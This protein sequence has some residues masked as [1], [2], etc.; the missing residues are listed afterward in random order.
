M[1]SGGSK[2]EG[3]P[4]V[5]EKVKADDITKRTTEPKPPSNVNDAIDDL[6]PED[7]ELKSQPTAKPKAK[8]HQ[9]SPAKVGY[10]QDPENSKGP[11][12][13]YSLP[14]FDLN[15]QPKTSPS[16]SPAPVVEPPVKPGS[17]AQAHTSSPYDTYAGDTAPKRPEQ[18]NGGS[19]GI[20]VSK[21]DSDATST[22]YTGNGASNTDSGNA[23]AQ[24]N[25]TNGIDANGS[26]NNSSTQASTFLTSQPVQS[27]L[28]LTGASTAGYSTA[29][30]T[31]KSM[32]APITP[33]T[34]EQ[35]RAYVNF[36]N[37]KFRQNQTE[38]DAS[39]YLPSTYNN[40]DT[41]RTFALPEAPPE[42]NSEEIKRKYDLERKVSSN[43]LTETSLITTDRDEEALMEDILEEFGEF[44]TV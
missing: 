18:P 36:D 12:Y 13:N 1:G 31:P 4:A 5:K 25:G 17:K 27:G 28:L 26:A 22:A 38:D 32:D 23:K 35:P 40:R 9:D 10:V 39:S 43:L 33:P 24:P 6:Y 21:A 19:N 2:S 7:A 42:V 29:A 44:E 30:S 14:H 8:A 41:G 16:R 11:L 20:V 3:N 34:H 15:E 37:S